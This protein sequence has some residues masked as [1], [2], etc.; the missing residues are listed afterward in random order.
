VHDEQLHALIGAT[1]ADGAVDIRRRGR[2]LQRQLQEEQTFVDAARTLVAGNATVEVWTAGGRTHRGALLAAD[3]MVVVA[4]DAGIAHVAVGAVVG[5]RP[6]GSVSTHAGR[7]GVG[8][9]GGHLV[10]VLTDLAE[11]RVP[12]ALCGD[13]GRSTEAW[14][15]RSAR[16]SC[17]S[18]AATCCSAWIT[19]PRWSSPRADERHS[20]LER[21]GSG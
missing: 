19:S 12:V 11:H 2:W 17:G 16:T 6:V 5:L 7:D 13:D 10:D 21:A 20:E 9:R 4:T 15:R 14:W 1:R 8:V 18:R 3:A